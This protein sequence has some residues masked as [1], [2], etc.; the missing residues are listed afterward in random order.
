MPQP[1]DENQLPADWPLGS[2]PNRSLMPVKVLAVVYG[3]WF[4][5][6]VVLAIMQLMQR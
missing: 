2:S 5:V 6:L 4:I 3:V 1:T